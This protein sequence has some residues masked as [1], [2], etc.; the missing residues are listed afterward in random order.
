MITSPESLAYFELDNQRL[1]SSGS[2]SALM[3][4]RIWVQMLPSVILVFVDVLVE[5]L[6]DVLV[7]VLVLVDFVRGLTRR[8]IVD[9]RQRFVG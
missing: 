2:I 1:N 3:R 6:V 5:V 4:S 7:D 8:E 9:I